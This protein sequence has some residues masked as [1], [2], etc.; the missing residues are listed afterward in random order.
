MIAYVTDNNTHSTILHLP[1]IH[2]DVF[3]LMLSLSI[4]VAGAVVTAAHFRQSDEH[5]HFLHLA[6]FCTCHYFASIIS[7][8]P[9]DTSLV[10]FRCLYFFFAMLLLLLLLLSSLESSSFSFSLFRLKYEYICILY[11]CH[12]RNIPIFVRSHSYN[13]NIGAKDTTLIVRKNEN[14]HRQTEIERVENTFNRKWKSTGTHTVLQLNQIDNTDN[15]SDTQ[16]QALL[17]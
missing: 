2:W 14:I 16:T 13:F 17:M 15:G 7:H 11:V 3:P 8:N 5:L 10:Q 1:S 9:H 6:L 12:H 4:V